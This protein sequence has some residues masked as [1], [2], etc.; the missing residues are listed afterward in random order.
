MRFRLGLLAGAAIGYVLGTRDGRG[1]YEQIKT[2]ADHL[3]HDQRV[4]GTVQA[5]GDAVKEKAPDLQAAA[6]AAASHAVQA[7]TQVAGA[8]KDKVTGAGGTADPYD[9][10]YTTGD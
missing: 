4:Q 8:A 1:R 10:K 2:Q 9:R 3:W 6:G 5:A 7:A